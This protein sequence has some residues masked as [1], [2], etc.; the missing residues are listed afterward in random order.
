MQ[1]NEFRRYF[2]REVNAWN[3]T[4]DWI[5]FKRPLHLWNVNTDEEIPFKNLMIV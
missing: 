1:L 3:V 5:L 2:K 4:D